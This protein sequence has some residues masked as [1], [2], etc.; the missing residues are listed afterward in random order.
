VATKNLPTPASRNEPDESD[1][2]VPFESQNIPA[3]YR[4]Y[5]KTKR[6]N[7]FA[8][9]QAFPELWNYYTLLDKIWLRE[10]D[11]LKV[12]LDANHVVPL[13]LFF[14]AHAKMRIS[15]ELGLSGCL[16]EARSILRDAVEFV[17]HAHRTLGDPQLQIVWLNKNE[18]EQS[19]KA[20]FERRK[21]EGLFKG[22]D[23]L[24]QIWGD[25]SETGSHA[26]LNSI[27]DRVTFVKSDD[28]DQARFNYCGVEPKMW[29]MSLFSML[30]ACFVMERTFFG[31]YE[32]RLKLDHILVGMRDK[33][34]KHKEQVR[35]SFKVRYKLKPPIPRAAIHTR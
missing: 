11:D 30:L 12:P 2:L 19:F 32:D 9:I 33:F 26:T 13:I 1:L 24:R 14:N 31:D 7:L 5:Y 15:I 29:A 4:E 34:E 25:L 6:N 35:E 16:A 18:D 8:T 28:G 10:L 3:D 22:L 27:S 21:K 20:A 17:A 23:E